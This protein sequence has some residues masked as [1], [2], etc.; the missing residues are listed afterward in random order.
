MVLITARNAPNY[1]QHQIIVGGSFRKTF[2][3]WLPKIKSVGKIA[4]P[5]IGAIV[6]S[7]LFSNNQNSNQQMQ[8]MGNIA[9]QV[10]S[11]PS[12]FIQ[13]KGNQLI[14]QYAPDVLPESVKQELR[15]QASNLGELVESN[16]TITR[17]RK[18]AKKVIKRKKPKKVII[19][20][21]EPEPES[22]DEQDGEGYKRL[23][24]QNKRLLKNL[25][26]GSGLMKF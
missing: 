22:N 5:A 9:N 12:Q 25:I 21:E 18:T 17:V 7:K 1:G 11:N 10:L 19:E 13:Q 4:L 16:P 8:Q 15:D 26:K 3:K 24:K 23:S 6:A 2:K 14:D 20:E